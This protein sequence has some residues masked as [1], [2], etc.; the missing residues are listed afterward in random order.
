M[1]GIVASY[2]IA[3][4]IAGPLWIP[5]T[6]EDVMKALNVDTG[7]L[8]KDTPAKWKKTKNMKLFKSKKKLIKKKQFI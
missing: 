7:K 3:R 1:H 8:G 4:A 2:E 5:P 6:S